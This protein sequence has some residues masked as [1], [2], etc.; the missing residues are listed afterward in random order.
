VG[1]S[2]STFFRTTCTF[3]SVEFVA[4]MVPSLSTAVHSSFVKVTLPSSARL[5]FVDSRGFSPFH[6]SPGRPPLESTAA[7]GHDL[8]ADLAIGAFPGVFALDREVGIL[9]RLGR[10]GGGGELL[11]GMAERGDEGGGEDEG[12]QV[13]FFHRGNEV[14]P[15]RD[16]SIRI[17]VTI[18]LAGISG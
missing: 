2:R 18:P 15:P 5:P 14:T 3:T 16:F 17:S 6:P 7:E 1:L 4:V 12:E 9:G 10:I 11:R 13:A 8:H